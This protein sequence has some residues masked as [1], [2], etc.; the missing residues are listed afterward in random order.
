MKCFP[1]QPGDWRWNARQRCI[2]HTQRLLQ[3]SGTFVRH[4]ISHEDSGRRGFSERT[5]QR[6]RQIVRQTQIRSPK[7]NPDPVCPYH[8][9]EVK[10]KPIFLMESD[11]R[12]R[13]TARLRTTPSA[14]THNPGLS[15]RALGKSEVLTS[16]KIDFSDPASQSKRLHIMLLT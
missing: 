6:V 7:C 16:P 1:S 12:Y 11:V 9:H 10:C 15:T 3:L 14:S 13:E 2:R 8:V 5:F 4:S